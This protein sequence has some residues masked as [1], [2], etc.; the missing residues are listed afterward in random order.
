MPVWV[1]IESRDTLTGSPLA[2]LDKLSISTRGS[3]G[4]TGVISEIGTE[5][6]YIRKASAPFA[7][8]SLGDWL[9][10]RAA[11]IAQSAKSVNTPSAR[12][13]LCLGGH[14][15][16]PGRTARLESNGRFGSRVDL[17]RKQMYNGLGA[18]TSR[19]RAK[20]WPGVATVANSGV[21]WGG[22]GH[23]R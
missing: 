21:A 10:H 1:H 12:Q 19:Q 5:T 20:G 2:M 23:D 3:D 22:L 9:R 7:V 16:H 15:R 8:R 13:W 14:H 11:I 4:H 17:C 6:S 18:G